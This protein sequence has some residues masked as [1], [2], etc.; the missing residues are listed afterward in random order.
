[1]TEPNL[2]DVPT[3]PSEGWRGAKLFG[4]S[5]P[6][7]AVLGAMAPPLDLRI[8]GRTLLHTATVGLAAG[9]VGAAFFAAL[10][11]AQSFFLEHLAGYTPLR[12]HGERIFGE[13]SGPSVLRPVVV[14]LLPMAGAL[15]AGIVC[16]LAP[17]TKGGGGDATIHAFHHQGGVVRRRVIWVKAIASILTL[18]SGGSGGREGPTM[19]MG[20]AIGSAIGRALKVSP[21]ERR[22]LMVAGVAAG[23]AAVF[24]TPLGAALLAAE[25]L[26]RDDF[27][28]EALIPAIMASV[29][30]Y[31][32]VI[33]IFG[34]STLF[35]RA[36]R[37][38]FIPK[39]LPLYAL[40]AI[41][42]AAVASIF[43]AALRGVQ[44]LSARSPLPPGRVQRRAG[45]LSESSRY[46]SSFSSADTSPRRDARWGSSG[47]ATG[48]R[49]SPSPERTGYPVVGRGQSSS[50]SSVA[51]SCWRPPSP[52]EPG[53]VPATSGRLWCL[54][55][56][57]AAHSGA[58]RPSYST[59]PASIRGRL[60]WWEW[61][62]S[63]AGWRTSLSAR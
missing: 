10:E 18:G 52:S 42:I 32:V 58:R 62:P 45:S 36:P 31:S 48:R 8:L 9:L 37:Y 16:Q 11:Y 34:E 3:P 17:E 41:M 55:G 29:I 21:R 46:R 40:L 6:L 22:I 23:M 13:G 24:R 35:A 61:V 19:Q 4:R 50:C 63:T 15:L 1:M 27:E 14:L 5:T 2:P 44:R 28:A 12:A 30:A 26:Y 57:S 51:R 33:S 38:L 25:I 53:E 56:S 7:G 49:R 39:H 47:A 59:T 54:A 43:L 60:P 20:G